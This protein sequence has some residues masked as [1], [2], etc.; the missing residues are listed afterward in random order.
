MGILR[1]SPL[2]ILV[3][4]LFGDL[5]DLIHTCHICE[6]CKRVILEGFV[7]NVYHMVT[8]CSERNDRNSKKI[9]SLQGQNDLKILR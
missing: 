8:G 2:Y 6:V 1:Y 9:Q 4:V 5:Q 3:C 7:V